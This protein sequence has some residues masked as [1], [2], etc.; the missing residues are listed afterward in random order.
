MA[1]SD[2][3]VLIEEKRTFSQADFDLFARLSGDANPI[4]VDPQY[5]AATA[6][7]APVAHGMLL[8]SAVRGLIARHYPGSRLR[9]QALMFPAPAYAGEALNV[10]LQRLPAGEADSGVRLLTRVEKPDGRLALQ[11]E[12]T[13]APQEKAA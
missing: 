7:A 2:P 1:V 5:A 13:L 11:G 9:E 3:G 10:R 4:H 6:F 12:C 8:F